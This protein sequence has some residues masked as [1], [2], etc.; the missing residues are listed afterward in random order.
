MDTTSLRE[1]VHFLTSPG[2]SKLASRLGRREKEKSGSCSLGLLP[3]SV[4]SS[5]RS[6]KKKNI[7]SVILSETETIARQH[8]ASLNMLPRILSERR[9][10]GA[11]MLALAI[12]E[13]FGKMVD[14]VEAG[15]VT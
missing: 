12:K 4:D 11:E 14:K 3:Q 5:V 1:L 7:P 9:G 6:L 10:M 8:E 15:A 2:F 13:L